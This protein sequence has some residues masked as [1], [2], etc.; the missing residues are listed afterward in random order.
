MNLPMF[1]TQAASPPTPSDVKTYLR[2][3]GWKAVSSSERWSTFQ[4]TLEGHDVVLDVPELVDASDY[5][6]AVQSMLNDLARVYQRGPAQLLRELHSASRDLIRLSIVSNETSD[7]RI[8]VETGRLVYE[9]ARDM[10]LSAACSAIEPKQA[11]PKRKPEI[12]TKLLQQA[13]FGQSEFGSFILTIECDVPI[14]LQN[15][16]IDTIEVE[17]LPFVR[18]ASLGLLRGL[19]AA[20]FAARES[21]TAGNADAFFNGV[22]EGLSANLCEAIVAL[23][24]ATQAERFEADFRFASSWPDLHKLNG[25][26][27]FSHENASVLRQGAQSLRSQAGYPAVELAGAIVRLESREPVDGGNVVM[28][29]NYEGRDFQ[30]QLQLQGDEYVDAVHAHRDGVI[31]SC[32]GDL[33]RSGRNWTLHDRSRLVLQEDGA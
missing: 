15:P 31:V 11:F 30:V 33:I 23:L 13:K 18:K 29:T 5:P 24:E 9:A 4:I 8:S 32:K 19:S 25:S 22:R 27:R 26:L 12:A 2:G 1:I 6:R 28:F 3:N 17:E 20:K 14:K 21:I 16:L 7:G 10:L